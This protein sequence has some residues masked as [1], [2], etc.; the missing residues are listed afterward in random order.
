MQGFAQ[1]IFNDQR[2]LMICLWI[3]EFAAGT[4]T[5]PLLILDHFHLLR[6]AKST[7]RTIRYKCGRL[8]RA[9]SGAL[10]APLLRQFIPRANIL[11]LSSQPNLN[12]I[13]EQKIYLF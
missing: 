5:S 10:T 13:L 11:F 6:Y 9:F 1:R 8:L 4:L 7:P 3:L 12:K 2:G